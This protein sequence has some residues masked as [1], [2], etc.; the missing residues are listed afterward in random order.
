MQGGIDSY[1]SP[2]GSKKRERSTISPEVSSQPGK[3]RVDLLTSKMDEHKFKAGCNSATAMVKR[4]SG[5]LGGGSEE[6]LKS[7]KEVQENNKQQ[8]LDNE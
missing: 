4:N 1:F 7:F 2:S 5:I 8:R 6:I 3:K